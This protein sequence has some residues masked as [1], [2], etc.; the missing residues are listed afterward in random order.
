[1]GTSKEDKMD[2]VLKV[3][4]SSNTVTVVDVKLKNSNGKLQLKQWVS[5]KVFSENRCSRELLLSVFRLL[6]CYNSATCRLKCW[7]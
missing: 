2:L 7:A 3:L 1:M 4:H 6:R 5:D